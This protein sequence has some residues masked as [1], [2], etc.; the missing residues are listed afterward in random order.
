VGT[1]VWP[2]RAAR[3]TGVEPP[4]FGLGAANESPRREARAKA[5]VEARILIGVI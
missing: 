2:Q 5:V 1:R 3:S 4:A